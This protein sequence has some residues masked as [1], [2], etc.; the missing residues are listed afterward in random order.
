MSSAIALEYINHAFRK[1]YKGV[2]AV[3]LWMA[4]FLAYFMA[5]TLLNRFSRFEGVAG[6][7]YGGVLFFYSIAALE[8]KRTDFLIISLMWVIIAL[9]SA[10]IMFGFLGI[11]TGEGIG[12]L[13]KKSGYLR[14]Y[15]A[16][17]AAV[18]KFSLGRII[19][20]V[21]KRKNKMA[22]QME[23]WIMAGMFF[24][25]F[26]LALGMF[27]MESE[28]LSQMERHSLSLQIMGIMFG[29]T[30]ILNIFYRILD[31]YRIEKMEREY[32]DAK[33]HLQAEQ[34]NELY[35][36]GRQANH[37]KHDMQVKMDTISRLL[38]RGRYEEAELCIKKLGSEWENCL[39]IP[40]D[41]GNEGLNAA[42]MKAVQRCKEKNIKFHYVVLGRPEEIES[43]DMGNL[44]DNI[45]MNGIEACEGIEGKKEVGIVIRKE[46]GIVEMDSEN[47]IKES[48]FLTN[49]E[50]KS[51]KKDKHRHGFGLD[52]I[53]KIVEIYDGKYSCWEE[54]G[55]ENLWFVQNI[56]LSIPVK[57]CTAES[58]RKA[59]EGDKG[60]KE[61]NT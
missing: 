41:T 49:P 53:R 42:L 6:L 12:A 19:L 18:L 15:S 48:V 26:V 60:N 35:K 21:Y 30:V 27:R 9:V 23:N 31:K 43:M 3:S 1:K 33:Q 34:L 24:L 54:E 17:A 32:L 22:V 56:C 14:T 52:T 37:M 5:V 61:N 13:L 29:I 8:G 45:L 16:L 58:G 36:I 46:N 10:Y 44:L 55:E 39:E 47:T 25:L 28:E 7:L 51:T 11:A 4:G 2:R 59:M 40:T 50:M 38:E 57:I 20:A